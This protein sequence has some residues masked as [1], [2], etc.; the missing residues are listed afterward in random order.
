M[1]QQGL[2]LVRVA[3]V[4]TSVSHLGFLVLDQIQYVFK[5]KFPE[6]NELDF[7]KFLYPIS[8]G[9]QR[10]PRKGDMSLLCRV[11]FF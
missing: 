9:N 7:K 3:E 6:I 1:P 2:L 11:S 5:M 8:A 10:L 4:A